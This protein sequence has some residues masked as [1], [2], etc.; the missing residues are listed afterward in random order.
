[1]RLPRRLTDASGRKLHPVYGH[2][3]CGSPAI[4]AMQARQVYK[5]TADFISNTYSRYHTSLEKRFFRAVRIPETATESGGPIIQQ[6][7]KICCSC[8]LFRLCNG[9]QAIAWR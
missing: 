6:Y 7:R 1:M 4:T 3:C 5:V 9:G 2:M 8:Y